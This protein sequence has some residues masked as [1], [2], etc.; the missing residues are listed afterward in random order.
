MSG[1]VARVAGLWRYPVKSMQGEA[2]GSLDT[3]RR[4]IRGDRLFAVHTAEGKFGSGKNTRRFR[5]LNGL[6]DFA[7]ALEGDTP[8]V[9]FP[10]GR[11]LLGDDPAIHAALSRTLGQ[12]VTLGRE[13]EVSHFDAAPIHLLTT[14]SLDW[15]RARLPGSALDP[16]RFRP[17]ILLSIPGAERA[18]Q[19]WIGREITIGSLRLAVTEATERCV[20][21]TMPQADLGSDA[22]VLR[23]LASDNEACLGVYAR[24]VTPGRVSIGDTARA[25]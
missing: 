1:V 18:E 19:A 5:R 16:R 11:R 2:A 22:G 7:A 17:N 10:D 6:L 12:P 24:I 23:A 3:D 9:T 4:G 20:M 14:A 25:G 8:L 15:L 21:T 13:G